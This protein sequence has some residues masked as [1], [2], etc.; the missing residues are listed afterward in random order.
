MSR[1]ILDEDFVGVA[2]G[3]N[4]LTT[5]S[6]NW[7]F[8][9]VGTETVTR[10]ASEADAPGILNLS[11]GTSTN[12]TCRLV[13]GSDAAST[14][15]IMANQVEEFSCRFRLSSVSDV[16]FQVGLF[17]DPAGAVS[18]TV[19]RYMLFDSSSSAS[20]FSNSAQGGLDFINSTTA[21]SATLFRTFRAKIN[22]AGN[23]AAYQILNEA[24]VVLA[25]GV[26]AA[27]FVNATPMYLVAQV[28]TQAAALKTARIDR[29]TL[30][31]KD[32]AR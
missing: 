31:S 22:G 26:H 20:M 2:I 24:G 25:R 7:Y 19:G 10:A 13:Y 9:G 12:D 21:P 30:R 6:G 15:F 1:L 18:A 11:T 5:S 8:D 4:A 17:D 27:N 28:S 29:I 16:A 3:S 14:G 32:L 23:L